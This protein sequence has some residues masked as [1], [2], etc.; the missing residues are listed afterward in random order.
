MPFPNQTIVSM[1]IRCAF[2][3]YLLFQANRPHYK[4]LFHFPLF[5]WP[6]D[7]KAQN[8]VGP[9]EWWRLTS[10]QIGETRWLLLTANVLYLIRISRKWNF[11]ASF[12]SFGKSG[13]IEPATQF[14]PKTTPGQELGSWRF[15]DE[16]RYGFGGDGQ[17]CCEIALVWLVPRR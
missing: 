9:R 14:P 16:F 10:T 3:G 12:V 8:T 7:L 15:W 6:E 13:V 11:F 2:V 4:T 17:F 1:F 5:I